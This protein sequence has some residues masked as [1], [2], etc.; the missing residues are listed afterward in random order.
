MNNSIVNLV[1]VLRHIWLG[2]LQMITAWHPIVRVCAIVA[3]LAV[4]CGC[5]GARPPKPNGINDFR[6]DLKSYL[7]TGDVNALL[8]KLS[9]D[10][11]PPP[12]LETI[13]KMFVGMF[14]SGEMKV[15]SSHLY[16]VSEYQ[17][18]TGI[19]GVY[20]GRQLR[21]ATEPTHFA[22]FETKIQMK[23]QDK[24]NQTQMKIKLELA[25]AEIEGRWRIIGPAFDE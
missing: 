24:N 15:Q 16:P 18:T 4:C 20:E 13:K 8:S 19:P 17:P 3:A 11:V 14:D 25:I 7:E 22:V 21:W 5:M 23:D 2:S 12:L 9:T 10:E 6:S 1:G